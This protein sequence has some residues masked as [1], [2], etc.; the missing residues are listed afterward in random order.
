M[1]NRFSRSPGP[2][3]FDDIQTFTPNLDLLSKVV[4]GQQN[5]FDQ[6]NENALNNQLDPLDVDVP[7]AQALKDF[8]NKVVDTA[9]N[10]LLEDTSRGQ[11]VMREGLRSIKQMFSPGGIGHK[12]NTNKKIAMAEF[13]KIEKSDLPGNLKMLA[14]RKL[15]KDYEGVVSGM[16]SFGQPVL[17]D[18]NKVFLPEYFD[19]N[20]A[21]LDFAEKVPVHKWASDTGWKIGNDGFM[22]KQKG[23]GEKVTKEEIIAKITPFILSDEK[24]ND[25]LNF[26]ANLLSEFNVDGKNLSPT[27]VKQQRLFGAIDAAGAFFQKDDRKTFSDDM[28]VNPYALQARRMAFDREQN[29]MTV[30]GRSPGFGRNVVDFK[31]TQEGIKELSKSKTDLRHNIKRALKESHIYSGMD[32]KSLENIIDSELRY[33]SDLPTLAAKMGIDPAAI[34]PEQEVQ[35]KDVADFL[36]SYRVTSSSLAQHKSN[37]NKLKRAGDINVQSLAKKLNI[38]F[39]KVSTPT[40]HAGL[41]RVTSNKSLQNILEGF[42][43]E[44]GIEID[45][46]RL[47]SSLIP[48]DQ[49]NVGSDDVLDVFKQMAVEQGVPPE[50]ISKYSINKQDLNDLNGRYK[51]IARETR[52]NMEELGEKGVAEYNTQLLALGKA[53]KSRTAGIKALI[54]NGAGFQTVDGIEMGINNLFQ[55][56][57]GQ[58]K[59]FDVVTVADRKDGRALLQINGTIKD[60]DNIEMVSKRVFADPGLDDSIEAIFYDI[61][62][63]STGQFDQGAREAA[64]GFFGQ[65]D[66]GKNWDNVVIEDIEVNNPYIHH[67]PDGR[68]VL[69]ITKS[70]SNK[71]DVNILTGSGKVP[72]PNIQGNSNRYNT[73]LDIAAAYKNM[74]NILDAQDSQ[75]KLLN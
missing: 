25:F 4:V 72:L 5:Q 61:M 2:V 35:V 33:I 15:L 3:Q 60:G 16:N 28:K 63:N 6:F 51:Q 18:F 73:A 27:E 65:K 38:P 66:L 23:T 41:Q 75:K 69:E 42:S 52:D 53:A 34:T 20:K 7:A 57:D 68:P 31:D 36:D 1:P 9:S 43:K 39:T 45:P 40:G 50:A 21:A 24:A 14:K 70:K 17:R 12:I 74:N 59:D 46:E 48:D 58:L 37:M 47:V 22:R 49:Y 26:E 44:W 11:E 30:V 10:A 8:T 56:F 19:L 32:E 67:L 13:E 71:F 29:M 64:L 54:Q 62:T 55:E